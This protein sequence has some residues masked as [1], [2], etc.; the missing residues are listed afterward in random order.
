[1]EDF[2]I[3][4]MEWDI[5]FL[6]NDVYENMSAINEVNGKRELFIVWFMN[7]FFKIHPIYYL[8]KNK[9]KIQRKEF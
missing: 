4:F 6:A 9:I 8:H 3:D 2:V 5:V 7:E 1:M